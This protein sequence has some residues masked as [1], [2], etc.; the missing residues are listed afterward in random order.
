MISSQPIDK[1]MLTHHSELTDLHLSKE[2]V[3][4]STFPEIIGNH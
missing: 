4:T 3:A 2:T 1:E